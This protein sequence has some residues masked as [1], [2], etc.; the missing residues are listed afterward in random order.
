MGLSSDRFEVAAI[1]RECFLITLARD[2]IE[3]PKCVFKVRQA[4]CSAH[5]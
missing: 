1:N 3:P 4:S 2:M 5:G